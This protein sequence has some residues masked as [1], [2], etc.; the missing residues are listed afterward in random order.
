MADFGI[1]RTQDLQGSLPGALAG[2]Q[3]ETEAERVQRRQTRLEH[4]DGSSEPP[5]VS[6]DIDPELLAR[7]IERANAVA[8]ANTRVRFELD[9]QSG[10]LIVKVLDARTHEVIRTIPPSDLL[11]MARRAEGDVGL[12]VDRQS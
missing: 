7:E 12:L 6:R 5:R 10:E 2:A 11:E 3:R 1:A 4:A 9:R 8:G